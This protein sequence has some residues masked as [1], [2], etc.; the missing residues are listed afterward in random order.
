MTLAE[1]LASIASVATAVGVGVAAYQLF[2]VRQQARTTFEDSL[3]AQYGVLIERLPLEALFGE[4]N[5]R[6]QVA[7]HL[8]QFYRYFDLCNPQF[9]STPTRA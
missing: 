9:Q 2:V 1:C 5:D 8:P 6:E 4:Q 7:D 3:N